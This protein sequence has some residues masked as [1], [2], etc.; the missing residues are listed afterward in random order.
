M[1]AT[2]SVSETSASVLQRIK[3]YL[4][5]TIT[6]SGLNHIMVI[7]I[8]KELTDFINH[9][10]VLHEFSSAKGDKIRHFVRFETNFAA[11]KCWID[12]ANYCHLVLNIG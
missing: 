5:S 7:H 9:L 2:N 8:H 6:Q 3:T 11:I 4:R 10:Q 12:F 1:P